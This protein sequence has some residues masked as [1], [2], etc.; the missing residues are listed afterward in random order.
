MTHCRATDIVIF[1]GGIAGLWLLNRLRAA[2]YGVV[3][4][5]Y[6]LAGQQ[7]VLSQGIIHGGLKYTLGGTPGGTAR[8]TAAMPARWRACLA[9][10]GEIDLR[11]VTVLSQHYFMWSAS[12]LR[13]RLKGFLGSK[14][15]QGQAELVQPADYPPLLTQGTLYRLP[16]FV[17]EV[18]SLLHELRVPHGDAIFQ[19][20]DSDVTFERD[21]NNQLRAATVVIQEGARNKSGH[22]VDLLASWHEASNNAGIP[23][24]RPEASNNAGIPTSW[25]EAGN[26]ALHSTKPDKSNARQATTLTARHFIFAAGAGNEALIKQA[27]LNSP[28]T[29]RRPLK[30]VYL[31]QRDL[32]E[33]YL[34]CVGSK[35]KPRPELTITT[36]PAADGEKIWYLGGELAE[37]G[38]GRTAE[39]QLAA[40]QLVLNQQFPW[41]R[42]SARG[43]EGPVV[44]GV[45]ANSAR[46][47]CSARG[48]EGPA[49]VKQNATET[50]TNGQ[51]GTLAIDR[52]EPAVTNS[53]LPAS[54]RVCAEAGALVVWPAKLT[55]APML[56]DKVL[57]QLKHLDRT[58]APA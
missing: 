9:G 38:A 13:S 55:L 14:G 22:Q 10:E 4:L 29:Q 1:G 32:P 8:A 28:K 45:G 25:H 51:W 34:H 43:L 36:H 40:A 6:G 53:L 58:H 46:H 16:D 17:L 50:S 31:K 41:L 3:L 2:G 27:K 39:A 47:R 56:A 52:A 24:S 15:L 33:A 18:P 37:R 48:L 54:A 42:F 23:A 5:E 30:M 11:R 35:L 12:S 44:D 21:Q 19:L 57:A 7:T 49:T 20:A 26:N